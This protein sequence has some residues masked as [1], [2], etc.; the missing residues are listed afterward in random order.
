MLAIVLVKRSGGRV[1]IILGALGLTLFAPVLARIQRITG[2]YDVNSINR[3]RTAL[4]RDANSGFDVVSYA[5]PADM[6]LSL[7]EQL[8]RVVLGP[9][10]WEW[11][12]IGPLFAFDA[13]VWISFAWLV[14]RGWRH[15]TQRMTLA[16]VLLPAFALLFTLALTSGNYGGLQRQR[17]QAEIMLL[18]LAGA[19]LSSLRKKG[20]RVDP[21]KSTRP[22]SS[23]QSHGGPDTS[24]SLSPL[25]P[26]EKVSAQNARNSK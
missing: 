21:F 7:P 12:L 23:L 9:F 8:P 10:P 19:G 25:T 17:V 18:P 15:C 13:L 14:W 6:L 2:T 4:T 24:T 22:C 20:Y 5:S 16:V 26:A 3:S 1:P 11:P